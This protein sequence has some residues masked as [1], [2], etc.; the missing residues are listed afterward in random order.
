VGVFTVQSNFTRGILDPKIAARDETEI[1]YAGVRQGLNCIAIPQGGLERAEGLVYLA[2]LAGKAQLFPFEFSTS[3]VYD[4]AVSDALVEVFLAGV[5]VASLAAPYSEAEIFDRDAPLTATQQGDVMLLF[6]GEHQT[7]KLV[8][9]VGGAA[10]LGANPLATVAASATITVSS[11]SHGL[12]TGM[13]AVLAGAADTNGIPAAEINASHVVTRVDKDAF[14]ITVT[15]QA[16]STGSGG[17]AA[18]TWT[19][20]DYWTLELVTYTTIPR[21]NF[22]DTLTPPETDEVQEVTFTGTW[23]ADDVYRFKLDTEYTAKLRYSTVPSEQADT[24]RAALQALANTAESDSITVTNVSAGGTDP[25]GPYTIAFVNADGDRDW[26]DLVAQIIKSPGGG[27]IAVAVD[28][29]GNSVAG[30]SGQERVWSDTRGWP[31]VGTFHEQRLVVGG[32][33]FLPAAT[34]ASTTD[35]PFDFATGTAQD[36]EAIGAR[37]GTDALDPLVD[38]VSLRRLIILTAGSEFYSP[39]SPVTPRN[40]AYRRDTKRGVAAVRAVVLEGSVVF[41]QRDRRAVRRWT[42]A[43][44]RDGYKDLDLNKLCRNILD[45]P[46]QLTMR[47]GTNGDYVYVVMADGSLAVL[48]SDEDE[49]VLAWT[50]RTTRGGDRFISLCRL[51]DADGQEVIHACVERVIDGQTVYY[52]EA[53]DAAAYLDCQVT[54]T[55]SQQTLWSGLD[56]LEGATVMVMADDLVLGEQEVSGGQVTTADPYDEVRVGFN[57]CIPLAETM[58]VSVNSASGRLSYRRK[59]ILRA[60][61]DVRGSRDVWAGRTGGRL[62]RLEGK[63]FGFGAEPLLDGAYEIRPLGWR[64]QPS[65]TVTQKMPGP[66]SLRAIEAEVAIRA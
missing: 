28:G 46:G 48:N 42:Y 50:Q 7:R 14:Q 49:G 55:D 56:H 12:V 38:I 26:P 61:I 1:Y 65:L 32:T 53:M 59:K 33:K 52:L 60:T 20:A 58:P 29:A 36:D 15:T 63:F 11:T 41:V 37:P 13:T 2:E 22:D 47:Q 51:H 23:A 39:D 5:M 10:A 45:D 4:V 40:I 16:S 24:I 64:R 34:W 57:T 31:R 9:N 43:D 18:I 19:A 21:F 66:W 25:K 3:Q 35:E 8:R 27:L 17:G 54:L 6:H 30:A 44:T 62:Q